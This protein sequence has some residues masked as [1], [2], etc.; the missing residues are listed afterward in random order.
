LDLAA[1]MKVYA[2]AQRNSWRELPL[3][4]D[5]AKARPPTLVAFSW[6][7]RLQRVMQPGLYVRG[8]FNRLRSQNISTVSLV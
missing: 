6:S 8:Q 3:W 1:A 4:T 2:L 7:L 5:G